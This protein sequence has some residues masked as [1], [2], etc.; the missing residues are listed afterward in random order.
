MAILQTSEVENLIVRRMRWS[1]G[2]IRTLTWKVFLPQAET[3]KVL[4]SVFRGPEGDFVMQVIS[5]PEYAMRRERGNPKGGGKGGGK[6]GAGSSNA[7][8]TSTRSYSSVASSGASTS[9]AS[10]AAMECDVDLKFNKRK[11]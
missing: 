3:P 8:V 10:S 7:S 1:V 4:G 2:E 9:V 11:R 5:Q 6:G